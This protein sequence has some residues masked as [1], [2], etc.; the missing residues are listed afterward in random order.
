MILTAPYFTVGSHL[1]LTIYLTAWQLTHI[2][3][4]VLSLLS[5][6]DV[7]QLAFPQ[8]EVSCYVDAVRPA[9][10]QYT[11]AASCTVCCDPGVEHRQIQTVAH[12][13][14]QLISRVIILMTPEMWGCNC[15]WKVLHGSKHVELNWSFTFIAYYTVGACQKW[16]E[17]DNQAS[18]IFPVTLWRHSMK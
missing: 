6:Q 17:A 3:A 10:G 11:T 16:H 15:V 18:C 2:R 4:R 12:K 1:A 13:R 14:T 8:Q 7:K 9:H 5:H